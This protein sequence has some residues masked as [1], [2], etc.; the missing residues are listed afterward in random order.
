MTETEK[1]YPIATRV[2]YEDDEVRVWDQVIPTGTTLERHRHDNDYALVTVRGGG[3]LK[4]EFHNDTGGK[5]GERIE[6]HPK[7]GEVM[8]I[9]KGHE[10]TAHNEG[11][12]YRAILV[13]VKSN[14]T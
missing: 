4:V 6:L 8:F 7:R 14:N 12:E 10:E 13:E 3:T 11:E 1:L 2:I 5:L 9:D